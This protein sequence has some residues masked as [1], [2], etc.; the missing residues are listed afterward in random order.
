M[1][2]AVYLCVSIKKY[3]EN[4]MQHLMVTLKLFVAS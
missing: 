1:G 2:L 3:L 4:T